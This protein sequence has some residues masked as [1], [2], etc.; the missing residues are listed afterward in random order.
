MAHFVQPVIGA[1]IFNNMGWSVLFMFYVAAYLAAASMWLF[2][3][4][5]QRF[6]EEAEAPAA[7]PAPEP[8]TTEVSDA[9]A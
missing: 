4:P 6:Y 9:R 7:P 5:R 3:D 1:Y 2:I 8:V